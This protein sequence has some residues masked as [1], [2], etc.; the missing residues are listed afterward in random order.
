[1]NLAYAELQLILAA[2]F[3]RY[4]GDRGHGEQRPQTIALYDTIR[5]RDVDMHSEMISPVPARDSKGIRITVH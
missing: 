2:I 3:R 1:M 4:D 5:E